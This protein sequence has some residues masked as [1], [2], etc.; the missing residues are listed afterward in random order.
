MT[1]STAPEE[2]TVLKDRAKLLGITYSPNIGTEALREKIN[3][4]LA[5]DAASAGGTSYEALYKYVYAEAMKL[6]RVRISCVD[7]QKL[8][9]RSVFVGVS[10]NFLGNINYQV[11]LEDKHQV[12]GTHIPFCV[13]ERLKSITY[14]HVYEGTNS[15]GKPIMIKKEVKAYQIE[16]L[17]QITTEEHAALKA[18]Q[19]AR[20][21]FTEELTEQI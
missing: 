11:P 19:K 1:V 18:D 4:K 21:M 16:V 6:I 2:L 9:H 20:N 8:E 10:N 17:P 12:N 5:E 15:Q 7:P 14:L 13:Y 3:A